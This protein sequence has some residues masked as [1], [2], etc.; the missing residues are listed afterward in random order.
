VRTSTQNYSYFKISGIAKFY[1]EGEN[2]VFLITSRAGET[3]L[4]S[5]GSND[6]T[7]V[8]PLINRINSVY[9]KIAGFSYDA[10]Y[11][12]IKMNAWANMF[13]ITQI[14][15]NNITDITVT[16]ATQAQY[17]A[18]TQIPIRTMVYT[19]D[20]GKQIKT[21]SVAKPRTIFQ[22]AQY[23]Y[24]AIDG[25]PTDITETNVI[26]WRVSSGGVSDANGLQITYAGGSNG[27]HYFW[28]YIP[29]TTNFAYST[30]TIAFTLTYI[31]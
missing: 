20:G 19:E 3:L 11:L 16:S 14:S 10:D 18:G 24:V 21:Y 1:G 7:F 17:D 30:R 23:G 15:G 25:F 31:A 27:T 6:R 13:S 9:G 29:N 12:Y 28:Y 2:A 22:S 5:A 26:G 8:T 4:I